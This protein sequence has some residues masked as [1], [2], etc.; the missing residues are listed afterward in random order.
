MAKIDLT[1]KSPEEQLRIIK[2]YVIRRK[3]HKSQGPIKLDQLIKRFKHKRY[4]SDK[5]KY[6]YFKKLL[7]LPNS[8]SNVT[9]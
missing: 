4:T 5:Q 8:Q 2:D 9:L 3:Q 6:Y 1:R 7:N